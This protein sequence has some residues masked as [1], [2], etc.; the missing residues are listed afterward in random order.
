MFKKAVRLVVVGC[1]LGL[2]ATVASGAEADLQKQIDAVRGALP[3]FAIPMREVGDRFQ[4]MWFAAKGGNWALAAY[5]SKY[6]NGS[7]N[8]AS[9]TKPDEYKVWQGFY[10]GA[11]AP[12]DKAI[13]AK[14]LKAFETAYTGVM[15]G[16]NGCHASMGY[17]FI[18]VVKMKTPPDNGIN[19]T[20]KSEP[21][22]VPK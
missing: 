14:D 17:G 3:K 15:E 18:K 13:Q 19:Y 20:V 7:M 2:G 9:V 6:M 10:S 5:M 11:F 1:I 22:D 4:N 16:C 8:P 21:G 12:V